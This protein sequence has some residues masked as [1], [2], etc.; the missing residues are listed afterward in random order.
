MPVEN[1]ARS[2]VV[3]AST[4]D[5]IQEI[6]STMDDESVG[7]IVITDGGEPAGIVTDRDLTT[8]VIAEGESPDGLTAEDVMSTDLCTIEQ[9]SGFYEA[10]ELMSEHGVRRLPVVDSDGELTGIITVDDLNELL[11]DEHQQLASVIQAQRPP[12]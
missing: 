11:A 8:Q 1:L 7:S 10:T 12:Y 9:N 4:D 5:S 6:A 2:D 3:T